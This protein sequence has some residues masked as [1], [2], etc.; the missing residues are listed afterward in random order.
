[1]GIVEL[2]ETERKVLAVIAKLSGGTSSDVQL[3]QIKEDSILT[4]IPAP[5]LYR[6]FGVLQKLGYIRRSG[7]ERSGLYKLSEQ[8]LD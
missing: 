7:G 4:D 3:N 1:M 8:A 6:A 2:T 5:S